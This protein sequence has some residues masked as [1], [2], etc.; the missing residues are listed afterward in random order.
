MTYA[1]ISVTVPQDVLAAADRRAKEL[2]RSR[3]WVIA[4]ALRQWTAKPAVVRE[5][6]A[7]PY[8]VE[9][10]ADA[11]RQHLVAD[12]ERTPAERLRRAADLARLAR[13]TRRGGPRAQIIGFDSYEDFHQWKKARRAAG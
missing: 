7:P 2:D 12:L 4:D 3:S 8:G 1:R 5:P 6:P 9:E 13:A 11:R 10:V